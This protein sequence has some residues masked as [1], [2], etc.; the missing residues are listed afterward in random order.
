M[1]A[2]RL[3]VVIAMA[4]TTAI[5]QP[6]TLKAPLVGVGFL[7]GDWK[8]DGKVANTG[9]NSTG[10]SHMTVA[11]DGWMLLRQDHTQTF[12][13]SGKTTEGFSQTILVYPEAGTLHAD[14]GDGEGHVIP[15]ASAAVTPG[16]SVVF[17][18]PPSATGP[19]FQ[20]SYALTRPDDL[21]VDFG[22]LLPGSGPIHRI[23]RCILHRAR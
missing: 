6:A 7:V 11:A 14:Y 3:S 22:M 10:T 9:G 13:A 21:A 12:D 23:A 19:D 17:T 20:L 16:R 1:K 5:A 4:A 8:G 18:A 15:Y 2:G